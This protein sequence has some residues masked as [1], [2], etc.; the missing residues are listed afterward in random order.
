MAS[1]VRNGLASQGL[2]G[3]VSCQ[4]AVIKSVTCRS[5][6]VVTNSAGILKVAQLHSFF[7][8]SIRENQVEA[9]YA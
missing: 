4:E 6:A 9:Q 2:C 8:I 7:F 5:S 3:I 1:F